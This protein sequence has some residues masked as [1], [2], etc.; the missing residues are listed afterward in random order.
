MGLDCRIVCVPK[1][2]KNLTVSSE[3]SPFLAN[4]FFDELPSAWGDDSFD[5]DK[6]TDFSIDIYYCRKNWFLY[7]FTNNYFRKE[8]EAVNEDG[9][10][11]YF[12]INEKFINDYLRELRNVGAIGFYEQTDD[13]YTS[14]ATE[15]NKMI[16]MKAV[17][18]MYGNLLDFYFEGDY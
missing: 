13:F 18:E 1:H 17:M 4:G 3:P 11:C 16:R 6:H 5:V 2:D 15:I 12:L 8:L 10:G 7:Q 9:N 14:Y